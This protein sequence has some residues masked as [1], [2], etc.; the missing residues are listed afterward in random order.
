MLFLFENESLLSKYFSFYRSIPVCSR[1]ILNISYSL[2]VCCRLTIY[3]VRQIEGSAKLPRSIKSI[4]VA[5]SLSGEQ[6][7]VGCERVGRT[8]NDRQRLYFSIRMSFV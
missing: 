1:P 5:V 4:N 6:T 3:R 8:T 2:L 7:Y